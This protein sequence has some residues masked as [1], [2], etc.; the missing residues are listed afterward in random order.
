MM[1]RI[2]NDVSGFVKVYDVILYAGEDRIDLRVAGRK[3]D[4]KVNNKTV[5]SWKKEK[6]KYLIM[7]I[8]E[9]IYVYRL[10]K[11]IDKFLD[12]SPITDCL[13]D[14]YI[15]CI[16]EIKEKLLER[17]QEIENLLGFN[18]DFNKYADVWLYKNT[19]LRAN[20]YDSSRKVAVKVPEYKA[21]ILQEYIAVYR[22]LKRLR[23]IE[24]L[25]LRVVDMVGDG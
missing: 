9:Y 25:M 3:A 24:R 22:G 8:T 17:K 21:D 11:A 14:D 10:I 2:P 20:G 13:S 18:V 6:G 1:L 15:D 12:I 5:K 16:D 19:Q 4:G 23:K 7:P